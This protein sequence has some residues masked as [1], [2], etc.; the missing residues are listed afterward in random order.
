MSGRTRGDIDQDEPLRGDADG[1]RAFAKCKVLRREGAA[2]RAESGD[3]ITS[4]ERWTI[5]RVVGFDY[6]AMIGV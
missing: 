2:S 3:L 6:I 4:W 5:H 1:E